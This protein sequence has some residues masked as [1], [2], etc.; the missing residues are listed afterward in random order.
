MLNMKWTGWL[1][2]AI[3]GCAIWWGIILIFSAFSVLSKSSRD[4]AFG[5]GVI[6]IVALS[7]AI[8]VILGIIRKAQPDR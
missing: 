1:V 6:I 2:T 3:A 4:L 7:I 8:P 5:G